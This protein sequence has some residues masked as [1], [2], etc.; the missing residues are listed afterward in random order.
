VLLLL[1]SIVLFIFPW[2]KLA[3]P[4]VQQEVIIY[5]EGLTTAQRRFEKDLRR[6]QHEGW[7]LV[8]VTPTKQSF[9]RIRQLT[10]IYERDN[11]AD[12]NNTLP[13]N[14]YPVNVSG[15]TIPAQNNPHPSNPYEPTPL[16]MPN[17]LYTSNPYE[18][19]APPPPAAI[20]PYSKAIFLGLIAAM[21]IAFLPASIGES[22]GKI[23]AMTDFG[24]SLF[25]GVLIS[26]F[27]MDWKG[28]L[29]ADGLLKWR[30]M[31]NNKRLGM[32]CLLYC[33]F[34]I[35][36]FIYLF[37]IGS[38]VFQ[39]KGPV[40]SKE[41]DAPAP[42]KRRAKIGVIVGSISTIVLLIGT[43]TTPATDTNANNAST[44]ITPTTAQTAVTPASTSTPSPAVTPTPTPKPSPTAKPTPTPIPYASF[45]DGTFVVGNDI[46]PG[47]YRTR[48]ASPGCYYARL[49]GFGGT[50][51]DIIANDNTDYPAIVTISPTD[52][53][54]ES[55][56]CGT[57]TKDLSAIT[58]SKTSFEDGMYIVGTDIKPG[59]YKS[60]GQ[61]GCYYARLSGFGGTIDNIIA[62]NNT[63]T[64][65]IVTV[66]A[67]DKG[68][69]SNNCG[70]WTKM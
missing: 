46:Q 59:T 30:Q 62:N 69:Q 35:F 55:N 48:E 57:W 51:D 31:S 47:T 26:M 61:S 19:T 56:N 22:S 29:T 52:K 53:G 40:F 9:G 36:F 21:V 33:F 20:P 60:R 2:R 1:F 11:T 34:P 58:A 4:E 7:S 43:L 66:S 17:T 6:R 64:P 5:K 49:K 70:T 45:S 50:V 16:P 14:Q 54:F 27:V 25:G 32:G 12:S 68:F 23:N 39:A 41:W 15:E 3:L 65:A 10:A 37:R 42:V 44:N 67:G 8:S 63:N 13:N 24:I 38:K 28:L 18:Q